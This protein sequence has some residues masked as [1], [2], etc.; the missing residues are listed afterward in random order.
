MKGSAMADPSIPDF[1]QRWNAAATRLREALTDLGAAFEDVDTAVNDLVALR[2]EASEA[3][4][5]QVKN[6][7]PELAG[8]A[9]FHALEDAWNVMLEIEAVFPDEDEP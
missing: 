1:A 8:I 2:E 5:E 3:E 4:F 9:D 6:V 7:E